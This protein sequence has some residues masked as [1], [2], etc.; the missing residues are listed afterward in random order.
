MTLAGSIK[1]VLQANWTLTGL[2]GTAQIGWGD[3]CWYDSAGLER[4]VT[5]TNYLG[6]AVRHY[7]G[8]SVRYSYPQFHVNIWVRV[9]P[10]SSG[11]TEEQQAEDMRLEVCRV[12]MTKRADVSPFINIVPVDEGVPLHEVDGPVPR[13]MRYEITLKGATEN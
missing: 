8:G 9:P 13:L 7:F 2:L 5:V 4:Q 1:A 6:G 3:G 10:G 11:E 12:V